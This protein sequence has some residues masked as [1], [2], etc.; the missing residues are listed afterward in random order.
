VENIKKL[1]RKRLIYVSSST[2]N[3]SMHE[4]EKTEEGNN[5]YVVFT[6][7]DHLRNRVGGECGQALPSLLPIPLSAAGYWT[8]F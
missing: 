1:R 2:L 4:K 3:K 6:S 5:G 7:T 8:D